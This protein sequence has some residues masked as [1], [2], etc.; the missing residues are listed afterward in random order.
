MEQ[1]FLCPIS[2]QDFYRDIGNILDEKLAKLT[3]NTEV[4]PSTS[5]NEYLTRKETCQ[6]LR[7]S[8][9]TLGNYV[10]QGI[11]KKY[12]IGRRVLFKKVEIESLFEV[13]NSNKYK[14]R[15]LSI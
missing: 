4:K 13:V 7:I 5:E 9:P 14:A 1:I 8:L 11:I 3:G 6:I 15:N 2:K 12:R 10:K